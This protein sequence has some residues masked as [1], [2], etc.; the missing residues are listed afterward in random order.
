MFKKHV[1][2]RRSSVVRLFESRLSK[3]Q[4]LNICYSERASAARN[5]LFSTECWVLIADCFLPLQQIHF[6]HVD[7]LFIPEEGD[8]DAQSYCGFRRCIGDNENREHLAL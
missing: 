2:S 8:Q 6:I 3:N 5:L 7:R 1:V 4:I